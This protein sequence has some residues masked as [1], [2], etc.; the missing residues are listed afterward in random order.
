M[1]KQLAALGITISVLTTGAAGYGI[2][3][4]ENATSPTGHDNGLV[5]ALADKFHLNKSDAQ[6]VF[7][8]QRDKLE[9]KREAEQV[10]EQAQLVK[11]GKL[12]QAQSNALTAKRAELKKERDTERSSS[13]TKTE[14]ERK[15]QMDTKRS[16]LDRWLS[17]QKIDSR[18]RYLLGSREHRGHD[19]HGGH[20]GPADQ[21]T[22]RNT[23]DTTNAANNT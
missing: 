16:E 3:S 2:V 6:A 1:K 22:Q 13:S 12:T 10:Q 17:D 15:G 4:A 14:S 20:R 23:T 11:D 5:Q 19:G 21:S 8:E 18:Y 9:A 7:N